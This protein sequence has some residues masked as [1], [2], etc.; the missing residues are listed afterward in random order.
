MYDWVTLLHSRNWHNTVNQ[1]YINLK[2]Y[3]YMES[4]QNFQVFSFGMKLEIGVCVYVCVFV[5]VKSVDFK[6]Q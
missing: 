5:C 3:C 4:D 1:L 6:C 2:K